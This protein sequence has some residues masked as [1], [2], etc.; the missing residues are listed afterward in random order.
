MTKLGGVSIS[1]EEKESILKAREE[2][3][4]HYQVSVNHDF[5]STNRQRD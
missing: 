4:A 2:A 5:R 3:N 1:D